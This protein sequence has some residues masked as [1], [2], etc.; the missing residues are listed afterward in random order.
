MSPLLEQWSWAQDHTAP[1]CLSWPPCWLR[2]RNL[3]LNKSPSPML[4]LT[5]R[6]E[7]SAP[8]LLA[9]WLCPQ[10][11]SEHA[12]G[13]LPDG[14]EKQLLGHGLALAVTRCRRAAP[15]CWATSFRTAA[16]ERQKRV[17]FV[18]CIWGSFRYSSLLFILT[19]ILCPLTHW[20]SNTFFS[21]LW[22]FSALFQ[23]TFLCSQFLSAF[24]VVSSFVWA[25]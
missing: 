9:E 3:V 24:C 17:V 6:E 14:E 15:M 16:W 19:H 7:M 18:I 12:E 13:H 10:H 23:A 25:F 21:D 4:D 11:T 5:R 8:F 20:N 2:L 1:P 22:E